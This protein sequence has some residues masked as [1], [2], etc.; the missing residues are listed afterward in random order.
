MRC[1]LA[2]AVANGELV[3]RGADHPLPVEV[4]GEA[5]TR[6][7]R[8]LE[9][10]LSD[11]A[12]GFPVGPNDADRPSGTAIA[13]GSAREILAPAKVRQQSRM[14]PA[15][16][17]G[18][19]PFVEEARMPPVMPHGIDRRGSAEHLAARIGELAP[20]QRGL[21]RRFEGP[22]MLTSEERRPA[23]SL[24]NTRIIVGRSGFD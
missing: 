23:Q 4:L 9:E 8:R 22:I 2:N 10:A 24:L 7:A 11:L 12:A 3:A 5:V 14:A 13:V 20:V 17:A 6:A 16:I 18:R 19:F 15:A 21:R 1:A